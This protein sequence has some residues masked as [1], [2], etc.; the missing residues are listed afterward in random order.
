MKCRFWLS[1]IFGKGAYIEEHVWPESRVL[2]TTYSLLRSPTFGQWTV[3]AGYDSGHDRLRKG[4]VDRWI[5]EHRGRRLEKD[6]ENKK[7]LAMTISSSKINGRKILEKGSST[8]FRLYLFRHIHPCIMIFFFLHGSFIL[9]NNWSWIIKSKQKSS[10][11]LFRLWLI[12]G[13]EFVQDY[14]WMK[15][16]KLVGR[17]FKRRNWTLPFLG[18]SLL[19]IY[20]LSNL[21]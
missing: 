1:D 11:R 13:S 4:K 3:S 12:K 16:I 15:K 17:S 9:K 2:T 8:M 7:Y 21:W 19:P 14:L 18:P 6:W 10:H 20:S 5:N